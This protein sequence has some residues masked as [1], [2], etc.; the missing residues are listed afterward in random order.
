LTE[1]NENTMLGTWLP[2]PVGWLP[3]SL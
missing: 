2:S 3:M 1:K